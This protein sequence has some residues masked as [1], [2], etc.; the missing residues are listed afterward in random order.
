MIATAHLD[1]CSASTGLALWQ[2]DMRLGQMEVVRELYGDGPLRVGSDFAIR[3]P[4]LEL[5][6][7]LAT[8]E[9]GVRQPRYVDVEIGGETVRLG[10]L[11]TIQIPGQPSVSGYLGDTRS[12]RRRALHNFSNVV[13]PGKSH[14]TAIVG[15]YMPDE[16]RDSLVAFINGNDS[17]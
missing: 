7:E 17:P 3:I 5:A 13:L 16:Y 1:A 14:L 11:A 8:L 15:G 4:R 10:Q 2:T 6:S 12:Q 9:G